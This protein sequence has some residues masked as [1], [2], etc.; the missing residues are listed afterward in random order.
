MS[1]VQ[2]KFCLNSSFMQSSLV[3]RHASIGVTNK[4]DGDEY[5][6]ANLVFYQEAH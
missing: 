2:F 3:L 5:C 6:D 1:A 4:K